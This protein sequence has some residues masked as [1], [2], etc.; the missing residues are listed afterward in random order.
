MRYPD[1]RCENCQAFETI[2]NNGKKSH[3][4]HMEPIKGHAIQAPVQFDLSLSQQRDVLPKW[5]IVPSFPPTLPTLWC[6]RI[7]LNPDI[8]EKLM[9]EKLRDGGGMPVETGFGPN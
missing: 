4:C 5:Q 8:N 6:M 7:L 9:K 2:E 1:V 3:Y